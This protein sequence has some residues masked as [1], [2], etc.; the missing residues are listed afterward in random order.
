VTEPPASATSR[1]PTAAPPADAS[2]ARRGALLVI[3]T[4]TLL[5][6]LDATIV[7]VALPT[8][9][10][11]LGFSPA[12]LE[13]VVTAYSLAYGGLLLLGGR[14]G[15]QFGRRRMLAVGLTL[16]SLSSLAAG[17]APDPAVLIAARF[18]QGAGAAIAAPT[19]LALIAVTFPAGGARNRAMS[20]YAA[21][22]SS[23]AAIGLILGGVLTQY[24]SWRWVFLVAVPIGLTAAG[25]AV[26]VLPET[27][28]ARRNPDLPGAL[29]ATAG[30]A[31]LVYGLTRA[32]DSTW[33]SPATIAALAAAGVFLLLFAVIER[34]TS[35]PLLPGRILANRSRAT[36]YGVTLA[37]GLALYGMAFF[38]M[39][40]C[41]DVLGYDSLTAGLTFLAIAVPLGAAAI[42]TGRAVTRTGTR[43]PLLLG[44]LLA[45]GGACWLAAQATPATSHAALIGPLA[46]FGLGLGL[47]VV[48]LTLTAL[49]G[50]QPTE[51]GIA[52]A[53]VPVGQQSGAA[54]GLAALGAVAA[55]VTSHHA[56]ASAGAL[57]D[58]YRAVFYVTAAVLATAFLIAAAALGSGRHQQSRSRPDT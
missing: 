24:A 26:R 51:A 50:A 33:S 23:G 36:A 1:P 9:R 10:S 19:A 38:L 39:L 28:T 17:M 6:T 25:G 34:R 55:T 7:N 35:Q 14:S 49:T 12:G 22:A 11:R 31:A 58:G 18:A 29:T 40:Y 3:A 41:Q 44:L 52:S 56:T 8:I 43:P 53:L 57:A 32:S 37:T 2:P 4:A 5:V 48:P 30:L 54:L 42:S 20:V 13:W 45:A 16:F 27:P 21:M 15:D 47:A 46:L